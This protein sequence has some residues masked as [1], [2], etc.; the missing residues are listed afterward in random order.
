M[1]RAT[2]HQVNFLPWPG[3]WHKLVSADVFVACVGFK[4]TPRGYE[5]RV[6]MRDTGDWAT[7][8]VRR[9]R[10]RSYDVEI[11]DRFAVAQIA[12]RIDH[13][14]RQRSYR[15]RD[16]LEPVIDYLRNSSE[17][18]LYRLNLRLIEIVLD[19]LG[20]RD[21]EIRLD[22]TDRTGVPIENSIADIVT[23]NGEIYLSGSSGPEYAN[24]NAM[25]GIQEVYVQDL[26]SGIASESVLHLI[27]ECDDPLSKIRELGHWRIWCG[28]DVA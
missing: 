16:R 3:F 5:N 8:P 4:Y 20:H 15:H 12:R 2:A 19:I 21:T 9:T 7:V 28:K 25:V 1:Q 14:S 6:R 17:T 24:R 13:W 18:H 23:G 27:A 22:L 10:G 11:A 26:P